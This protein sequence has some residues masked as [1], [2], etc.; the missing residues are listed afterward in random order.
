MAIMVPRPEGA[1][2]GACEI[3]A[4]CNPCRVGYQVL[5][6]SAKAITATEHAQYSNFWQNLGVSMLSGVFHFY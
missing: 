2:S 5:A 4:H 3:G 6:T 1:N